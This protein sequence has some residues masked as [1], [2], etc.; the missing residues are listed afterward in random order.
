MTETR[1]PGVAPIEALWRAMP[2]TRM[3]DNGVDYADVL[4]MQRRTAEGVA[5]DEAAEELAT[6]QLERARSA[7]RHGHVATAIA[8]HRAAA[9]DLLFAQMA[10]N[11]DDARK[12]ALYEAFAEAVGNAAALADPPWQREEIPFGHGRM[13]GWL[14]RPATEPIGAVVVFGGQSGWG[15]A[16]LPQADALLRRGM[17]VL[18]AEGP[19]QGETRMC[20]EILLDVDVRAAYSAFVDR[21]LAVAPKA[22]L[23]GNSLGGLYAATTAAADRRVSAVCVNS[24]P[25]Q[26]RLLQFRTFA[27]QAAA[28]LGTSEPD[29]I[30]D[31]FD[32]I[33]FRPGADRI[34]CP[35]LV[36]HG[37]ADPIVRA[38]E[39]QPFLD[40]ARDATLRVWD[41]GEHTIYN[42]A[43]ERTAYVADWF[44]D[45][46]A[47]ARVPGS[48][49]SPEPNSAEVM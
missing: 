47:G 38:E 26:P 33:A 2:V 5:W 35:L 36:L 4:T 9:A 29:A 41:D 30:Q 32:R 14:L 1:L 46:F 15:A 44:A 7:E 42:H 12:R 43:Q 49:Q 3:L 22:G 16:Y 21:A 23:W 40:A 28:M 13:N 31:N 11:F 25:A 27:E 10:F 6:T 45:Q 17:A 8:A 39:Q 37:E 48:A 24:A 19:G 20:H 18:L 34:H